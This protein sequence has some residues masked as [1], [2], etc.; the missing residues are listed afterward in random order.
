MIYGMTDKQ[1]ELLKELVINPLKENGAQVFIFGSR[2]KGAHHPHSDVDLLYKLEPHLQL[3]SGFLSQLKEAI[4][5]SRFPF[6]VDLVDENN[7][8]ESYREN[9]QATRVEL[10]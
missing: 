2:V 7:L 4:E 1:Y 6:T 5:E 8:A 9:V 10:K 3:K